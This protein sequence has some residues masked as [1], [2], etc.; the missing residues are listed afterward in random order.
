[1]EEVTACSGF[2]CPGH[3]FLNVYSKWEH[4]RVWH[5]P[6]CFSKRQK[7]WRHAPSVCA[8]VCVGIDPAVAPTI[9]WHLPKRDTRPQGY[10]GVRAQQRPS[11]SQASGPL[12]EHEG[13]RAGS[14]LMGFADVCCWSHSLKGSSF[15]WVHCTIINN[16]NWKKTTSWTFSSEVMHGEAKRCERSNVWCFI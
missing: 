16:V 8:F 7:K 3:F 5:Q 4:T 13:D 10:K 6:P 2:F 1:M 14:G 15:A 9:I 11:F 12:G